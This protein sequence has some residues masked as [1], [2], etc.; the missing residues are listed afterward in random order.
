[1]KNFAL[2][3]GIFLIILLVVS[4]SLSF[5]TLAKVNDLNNEIKSFQ[6]KT[7]ERVNNF[8]SKFESNIAKIMDLITPGGVL[9]EYVVAKSFIE[10]LEEDL[11]LV[12]TEAQQTDDRPYFRFFITGK[13]QIW[14]GLK[15]SENDSSYF[16][17]KNFSPGLSKEKF[18]YFKEPLVETQYTMKVNSDSYI[19]TANPDSVYLIFFGFD[20]GKLVRMPSTTVENLSK[21]FNLYIPGK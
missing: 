10:N 14:I 2:F 17:Q 6:S 13:D 5:L 18:F 1:M 16:F 12:L 4:S 7:N 15:N 20:S 11:A 19:R 3:I 8:T 9:E 21:E